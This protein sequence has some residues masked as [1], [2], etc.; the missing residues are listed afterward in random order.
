MGAVQ[1][2][3]AG[4]AIGYFVV[5]IEADI[6]AVTVM[7]IAAIAS[8]GG[9]RM[10]LGVSEMLDD[11]AGQIGGKTWEVWGR[12]QAF[13]SAFIRHASSPSTTIHFNLTLPG[14]RMI[15]ANQSVQGYIAKAP[16]FVTITNWEL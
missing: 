15:D 16:G 4:F 11:F 7:G 12:G 8:G 2:M 9:M 5:V 13:R 10:A 6:I 1:G 14:G 3:A